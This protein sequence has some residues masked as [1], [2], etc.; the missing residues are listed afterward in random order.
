MFLKKW[1]CHSVKFC[2]R[3]HAKY[4]K[5]K[6]LSM[7]LY[8]VLFYIKPMKNVPICILLCVF[9]FPQGL[10]CSHNLLHDNCYKQLQKLVHSYDMSRWVCY[11]CVSWWFYICNESL[12]VANPELL[13]DLSSQGQQNFSATSNPSRV[14]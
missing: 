12:G 4:A 11:K 14:D 8:T 1:Y 5:H 6:N 9:F 7:F 10:Q 2:Q 3:Y 13:E